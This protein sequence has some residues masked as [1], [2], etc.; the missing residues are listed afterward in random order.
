LTDAPPPAPQPLDPQPS[1]GPRPAGSRAP[2]II[3]AIAG[4][5]L[6]GGCLVGVVGA[7]LALSSRA[8]M[9]ERGSRDRELA[10]AEASLSPMKLWNGGTLWGE[11]EG[12]GKVWKGGSNVGELEPDGEVWSRGTLV[13]EIADDG[14][15]WRGGSQIGEVEENGK[16]WKGGAQVAEVE[17]DGKVWFG[18]T[19]W[20]EVEGYVPTLPNRKAVVAWIFFYS[21]AF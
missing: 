16:V 2:I 21:G 17:D 19:Q 4:V 6:F 18:G 12:N 14:K 5:L 1:P 9:L 15:V 20:G 13:G 10:L 8:E 11:I 7:L 3:A